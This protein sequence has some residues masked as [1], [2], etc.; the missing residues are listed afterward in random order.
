MPDIEDIAEI[1]EDA[2]TYEKADVNND[3]EVNN[4]DAGRILQYDAGLIPEV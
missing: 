3:G 1:S 4:L 2:E